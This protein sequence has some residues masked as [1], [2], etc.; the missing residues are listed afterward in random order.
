MAESFP[1]LKRGAIR[2][3][4]KILTGLGIYNDARWNKTDYIYTFETGSQI[5]FFSADQADK[6]RGARRDR[7]FVNEAN[8]VSFEAFEQLEVRTKD[9]VF[10]DYNPTSEFWYYT[11]M[12]NKRS[13]IEE[14]TLTYKDNEALA[15]DIIKSIEQRRNRR[16]WWLVYGLGKLGEVEGRIYRGWQQIEKIPFEAKIVRRG[17]DF[18]YTND[19]SAIVAI[20]K[21]NNSFILDEELYQRGMHNKPIADLIQNLEEPQ[22][23]VVADSAEP[24]SID[25]IRS[26]GINILGCK[27][28]KNLKKQGIDYVQEQKIQVTKRSINIWR[29]YNNYLWERDKDG[30]IIND[31]QK[32]FDH[33]MD[34]IRY[35]F[36]RYK[37]KELKIYQQ[38]AYEGL[39]EF[40]YKTP[41][42]TIMGNINENNLN[43]DAILDL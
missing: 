3:F 36:D 37:P 18:G 6:V 8:N 34:A 41:V 25:E 31:P 17:L 32:G 20:Y 2:D 28:G 9:Y 11:E 7:L 10:I 22:T 29:E 38:P 43:P 23:L 16:Q 21:L 33:S 24:K 30:H 4:L 27:K 19:P 42:K 26:Y 5:E 40:E 14:L 12:K 13:D 35:G 1:H 15:P 39:S